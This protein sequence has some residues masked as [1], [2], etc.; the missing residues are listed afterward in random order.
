M[1]IRARERHSVV[2]VGIAG[3]FCAIAGLVYAGG[4]M[5]VAAAGCAWQSRPALI[6]A[7]SGV[8][9][10]VAETQRANVIANASGKDTPTE[11]P[12]DARARITSI[13]MGT[14]SQTGEEGAASA[15]LQGTAGGEHREERLEYERPSGPRIG[16]VSYFAWIY[17]S[18][19]RK[20]QP[21]GFIRPGTSV[22][23]ASTEPAKGVDCKSGR[24]MQVEPLG[25][26]CDDSAVTLD[27][28]SE[29][30]C[31][32]ERVVKGDG[33]AGVY[34]YGYSTGAPMFGRFPDTAQRDNEART[35]GPVA[36]EKPRG[37]YKTAYEE[38]ATDEVV[39]GLEVM[40]EFA[41]GELPRLRNYDAGL[42]RKVIPSGSLLAFS[43]A[44]QH[45]QRTYLLT[46]D[47]TWVP[48]ERVR[49]FSATKFRG[50][51]LGEDVGLPL[52]WTRRNGAATFRRG[53][54][55][56]GKSEFEPLEQRIGERS[57][58]PLTGA[59]AAVGKHVYWETRQEGV[60]V[61]EQD[62]SVVDGSSGRPSTVAAGQKWIA[63]S[64]S[65]G[66]LTLFEGEKAVFSTLASPGRGGGAPRTGM[67][68]DELVQGSF[69]PLGTYRVTF[70]TVSTTMTPEATP[71]PKKH[72]IQDVPH[73]LYFMRPFAIHGAYWHEDFGMPKSGGCINLSPSDAKRV[74]DWADPQL[75]KDWSGVSSSEQTGLGTVIVIRR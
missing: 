16:A 54:E 39:R 36:S 62:V 6:G 44:V 43:E 63:Y 65:K 21:I 31:A 34:R 15:R 74:F 58:V 19:N 30:F 33:K 50:V 53:A 1:V 70:K 27:L 20:G 8:S 55:G 35:Y 9:P 18:T 71:F 3:C 69:T 72:W 37:K 48:A 13:E 59:K 5:G 14:A 52:A 49:L 22:A 25:F 7:S 56:D 75:P 46:P 23:L 42:V 10:S 26:V 32:L 73:T 51:E 66:T 28:D 24:W 17:R 11:Q 67:S 47:L 40:P 2:A 41:K 38:L 61:R 4:L 29:V 57:A 68:I 45:E 64:A 12:D 60:W